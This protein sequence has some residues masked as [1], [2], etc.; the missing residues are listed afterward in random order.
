[1]RVAV[2]HH[3]AGR[4]PLAE[5]IYRRV[6]AVE[7]DQ[8][9][10]LRLLGVLCQ[11]RGQLAAAETW[12]RRAIHAWPAQAESHNSLGITLKAQ[13]RFEEAAACYRQAWEL[14]PSSASAASNLGNVLHALG[15][16]GEAEAWF[17]R[18]LDLNSR[19]P[20]AHNSLGLTYQAQGR[21]DEAVASYRR[22]LDLRPAYAEAHLNL[23]AALKAQGNLEPAIAGYREGLRLRPNVPEAFNNLGNALQARGDW[24]EAADCYRQALQLKPDY[25]EAEYNLANTWK[26]QGRLS[27]AVEAYRRAVAQNP[28]LVEARNNLGNALQGQGRLD[29]AIASF[30]Q[31]LGQKP[32]HAGAHSNWIHALEHRPGITQAELA[33]VQAEFERRHASPLRATWQPHRNSRDADRRLRLGFVSADLGCHPVGYFLIRVLEHLDSAQAEVVCYCDRERPDRLTARFRQVAAQWRDSLR[34]GDE[35]LTEQIRADEIDIL[36]DLAGHTARNRLLV[37]ARKPAPVQ[38]TWAGYPGG[39]GLAAM[40]YLLADRHQVPPGAEPFYHERVLRMPDSYVCYDPPDDAP[41]VSPL[42]AT[43]A[44]RITFASFNNPAKVNPEVIAVWQQILRRVP[45]SRLLMKYFAFDDRGVAARYLDMFGAEAERVEL[46]G[47][48]PH[49]ELLARYNEIDIALDS[50]PYSGGLTTCEALWMGVPVVT[51]PGATFAS[52]HALSHLSAAGLTETIAADRAEYVERAVGLARD[53]P[54]LA[55]LRADLRGRMA[56]SPLCDGERF[57]EDLMRVLRTVWSEW[58]AQAD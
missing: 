26:A 5:E 51:C 42:P 29:E 15:R 47:W 2:E 22:A 54:R 23:A 35:Q 37:F 14:D 33:S 44:G 19:L 40:D 1:L 9:D 10:A 8:P 32:D 50:F 11:Q 28:H 41:P 13:G 21:L 48:S 56:R 39:T 38:I 57:A 45:G 24:A 18:A 53:L 16:L 43:D 7:P 46:S 31:A 27:E 49:A 6:L 36:F 4:L 25:A 12:L 20:E 34:L 58:V 3:Q 17:G 52:R 30:R 55:A